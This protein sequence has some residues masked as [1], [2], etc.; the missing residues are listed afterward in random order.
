MAEMVEHVLDLGELDN[1]NYVIKPDFDDDRFPKTFVRELDLDLDKNLHLENNTVYGYCLRLS[2]NF[3]RP[4]TTSSPIWTFAHISVNA[5]IPYVKPT[6]SEKGTGNIVIQEAR[7]PCLEVQDDVSFIPND[8]EM[9]K[10]K[11]GFQIIAGPNMG[12]KSTYIRQIGVI[13]LMAQT[14]CFV[15]CAEAEL[16]IFDCILARVDAGDS[17][18]KGVST[19]MAEM[20]QTA[21][22]LKSASKDSLIII[23]ELGQGTSTYDGFGLA[24]AISENIATEIN[25]MSAFVTKAL[26]FMP[27]NWPT[28]LRLAKRKADELEDFSGVGEPPSKISDETDAGAQLIKDFYAALKD[29]SI[30]DGEDIAMDERTPDEQ[31]AILRATVEQFKS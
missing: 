1:H 12:G 27:L 2:K 11:S 21:T 13:A 25:V 15:P 9:I 31:M 3:L 17:Q 7:H 24:W 10:G 26:V 23:D 29:R 4:W 18:L 20:L 28:F 16:P 8:H 22:I 5:P 19:F 6:L 14:G 30:A